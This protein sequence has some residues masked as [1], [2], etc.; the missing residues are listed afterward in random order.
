MGVRPDR[1]KQLVDAAERLLITEGAAAVTTRRLA[2]EAGLNQALVHYHFGS[3]ADVLVAVLDRVGDQY[4]AGVAAA[5]AGEEPLVAR[6]RRHRDLLIGDARARGWPK[7][8]LELC[9]LAL[10]QPALRERLAPRLDA[11]RSTFADAVRGEA[12]RRD[13]PLSED[14]VCAVA[15]LWGT[16]VEGLFVE[17]LLGYERGHRE[18]LAFLEARLTTAFGDAGD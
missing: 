15:T 6:W 1:K 12:A 3:M 7:I 16:A 9:T 14:E 13:V 17:Q 5:F 8:W 10:N 11:L 2:A 18:L 4:A